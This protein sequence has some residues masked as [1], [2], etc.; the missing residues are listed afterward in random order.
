M[1]TDPLFTDCVSIS[2]EEAAYY[3]HLDGIAPIVDEFFTVDE[4][5]DDSDLP[6]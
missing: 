5:D 1:I 6:F 3:D 4:Q 2:A